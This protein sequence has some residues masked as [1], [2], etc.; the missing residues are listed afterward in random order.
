MDQNN[1]IIIGGNNKRTVAGTD[2]II[3]TGDR[4]VKA[5]NIA[6]TAALITFNGGKGVVQGDCICALTG[7]PHSDLSSTVKA[8]K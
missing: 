8:G 4:T 6:E 5:A 3:I 1:D 2:V 7:K